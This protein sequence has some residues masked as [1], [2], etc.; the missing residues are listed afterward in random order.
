MGISRLMRRRF[1]N[2]LSGVSFNRS[3]LKGIKTPPSLGSDSFASLK[4][5]YLRST[6]E[7]KPFLSRSKCDHWSLKSSK[8][9]YLSGILARSVWPK[10]ASIIMA[11]KRFRKI[12][13]TIT[14]NRKWKAT[15]KLEPQ[16]LGPYRSAG[17]SPRSTML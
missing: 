11:M 15:A 13:E 12:W 6:N 10:K 8:H 5:S 2:F 7:I 9:F 3:Y 14:W 1:I 17:S 4:S 16:P